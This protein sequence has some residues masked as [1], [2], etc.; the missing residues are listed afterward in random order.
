MNLDLLYLFA[1][2]AIV[3]ATA[4]IL[5]FGY[6]LGVRKT[7]PPQT[8]APSAEPPPIFRTTAPA[9]IVLLTMTG[10]GG[11]RTITPPYTGVVNIGFDFSDS[12]FSLSLALYA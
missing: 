10:V 9:Q 6:R 5:F 8:I 12:D 11:Y 4:A 7:A 3:T 1:L 2:I